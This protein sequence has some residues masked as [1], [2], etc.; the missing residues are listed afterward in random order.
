MFF[1]FLEQD[2]ETKKAK[3]G[4][5]VSDKSLPYVVPI[6]KC[7]QVPRPVIEAVQVN[8]LFNSIIINLLLQFILNLSYKSSKKKNFACKRKSICTSAGW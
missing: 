7:R 5:R 4:I 3:V 8:I 2:L 6:E 1:I